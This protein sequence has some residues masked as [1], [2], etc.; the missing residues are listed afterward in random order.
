MTA[1]LNNSKDLT[2]YDSAMET[3]F[4]YLKFDSLTL[5]NI[6]ENQ[7]CHNYA[8]LINCQVTCT[9]SGRKKYHIWNTEKQTKN[10]SN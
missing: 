5:E 10:I 6:C 4:C 8:I 9:G 7:C 2:V 3:F 1:L